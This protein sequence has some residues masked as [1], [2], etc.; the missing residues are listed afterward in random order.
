MLK[1][2]NSQDIA[3][4]KKLQEKKLEVQLSYKMTLGIC[5]YQ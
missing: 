1:S 4:S 3:K 2:L 5:H